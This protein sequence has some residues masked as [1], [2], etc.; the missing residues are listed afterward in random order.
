MDDDLMGQRQARNRPVGTSTWRAALTAGLAVCTSL[1]VTSCGTGAATQASGTSG[2][3]PAVSA[4]TSAEPATTT[5]SGSV[6]PVTTVVVTDDPAVAAAGPSAEETWP[7]LLATRLS[8]AGSPLALTSVGVEGA[9]FAVAGTGGPTFTDLVIDTVGHDIQLVVFYDSRWSTAG[10]VDVT[11]NAEEA[12]SA[13]EAAAPDAL[14]VVVG[15][16]QPATDAPLPDAGAAGAV[17]AAVD[18]SVVAVT[19]VDPVAEDWPTGP[20]QQ[21]VTD[22]LYPHVSGLVA[23]LATSGAFD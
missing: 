15:P 22:L 19:Y 23:A 3:S 2:A 7:G 14:V 10:A 13:V 12:L 17:Q 6:H 8:R 16:W 4:E 11:R 1:A 18:A 20:S 9:G 21:D 5:G